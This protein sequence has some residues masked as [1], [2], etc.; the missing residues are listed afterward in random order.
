LPP[1]EPLR[2][3]AAAAPPMTGAEYLSAAV[4][5]SLWQEMAA[6]FHDERARC[7]LG[8][9]DLLRR[10]SPAWNLVGRVHFNLA[11]NRKDHEAP[12]AF[13]AT[14]TGH[15]SAHGKAQHLPLGHALREYAGEAK[16]DRLEEARV[17]GRDV[18]LPVFPTEVLDG[19]GNHADLSPNQA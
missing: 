3:L 8:A 18:T 5:E 12:F 4:L 19:R 2:A 6:A 13:I 10:F 9:Q 7:G 11:L 15:L 16:R 1:R 14:Y 17:A